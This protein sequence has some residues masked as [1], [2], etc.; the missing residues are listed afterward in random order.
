MGEVDEGALLLLTF[1]RKIIKWSAAA[2][3][4]SSSQFGL[5]AHLARSSTKMSVAAMM[6]W[7]GAGL[8]ASGTIDGFSPP[9]KKSISTPLRNSKKSTDEQGKI[10]KGKQKKTENDLSFPIN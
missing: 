10:R 3:E 8:L 5:Q 6:R 2:S 9:P 4:R 1:P 7:E